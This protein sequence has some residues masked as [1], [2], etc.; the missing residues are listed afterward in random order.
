MD[1]VHRAP[2][3]REAEDDLFLTLGSLTLVPRFF[4]LSLVALILACGG[5]S[6]APSGPTAASVAVQ[7]SDVPKGM[8]R[9]DVSGDIQRFIRNEQS[10]DPSTSKSVAGEW[11]DAQKS[12]A[13]AAYATVYTDSKSHCSDFASARTDPGVVP[14]RLVINF[15]IQFKDSKSAASTYTSG[16]VFGVSAASL[17]AGKQGVEGTKTGLSPNSIVVDFDANPRI[18]IALWQNKSFAVLLATL[19]L[20]SATGNKIATSENSR[21]K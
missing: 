12:G 14:Y 6:S 11:S 4:V 5:S 15:T 1:P 3:A 9:C 10:P 19:N 2:L 8:V 16:S 21:I 18:F 13:T 17:S 20:D 7:S